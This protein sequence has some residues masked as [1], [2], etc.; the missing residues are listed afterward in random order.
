MK[1]KKQARVMSQIL[2]QET[3]TGDHFLRGSSGGGAGRVGLGWKRPVW[4]VGTQWRCP[5]A[6]NMRGLAFRRQWTSERNPGGE[7]CWGELRARGSSKT[8]HQQSR[9]KARRA[10]LGEG[11]GRE[12]AGELKGYSVRAEWP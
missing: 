2:A 5:T 3:M 11:T 7:H 8:H 10:T 12:G 1:E 6:A 4:A 9:G